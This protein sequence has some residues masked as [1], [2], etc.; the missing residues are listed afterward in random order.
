MLATKNRVAIGGVAALAAAAWLCGCTPAGPGSLLH[1]AKLIEQKKYPEAVVQL[2]KATS[3]MPTNAT[4]WNYLGLAYQYA[5]QPSEAEKAY[6]RALT[7]DRD[8]TEAHYNLGCLLLD[9][10]SYDG[11]KSHLTAY[12]MRRG[13]SAEA[14]TKL[15][16]AQLKSHELAA[17]EKSLSDALKIN[18][19]SAEALNL[20][21]VVRVERGR[22]AEAL[23]FFNSALSQQH[24]YAPTV[25]NLAVLAQ[26][27]SKDK[28]A[29]LKRYRE[30]VSLNPAQDKVEQIKATMAQLESEINP[31]SHIPP[32]VT[33]PAPAPATN[34]A[35]VPARAQAPPPVTLVATNVPTPP[36]PSKTNLVTEAAKPNPALVRTNPVAESPKPASLA[37]L[38]PPPA[39]VRTQT[40]ETV[41]V[42]SQPMYKPGQDV[43]LTVAKPSPAGDSDPRPV[44]D[45]SATTQSAAQK[46]TFLQ[47]INPLNLLHS[48]GK[49]TTK[50][51]TLP[52][53]DP[54]GGNGDLAVADPPPSVSEVVQPGSA[55]MARYAY[56]SPP[57]ATQGNRDAA[58]RLCAQGFQAQQSGR[59]GEAI[60]S[61]R[62]AV[63]QDP[64]DYRANYNLAVALAES[65]SLEAALYAY[66]KA[67]AASPESAEARLNF[68]LTLKQGRYYVDSATELEKVVAA[69]PS[70]TS[71][72]LALGNLYAQQLRQPARARQ[73]Y[74]KVLELE[75]GHREASS[76]H[77]WLVANPP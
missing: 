10:G 3:L 18:P 47:K 73:H 77:Y 70:E 30:Y 8:L 37:A 27:Y 38:S 71:A 43:S 5:G 69:S 45:S 41:E 46:R 19:R 60:K 39:P 4:A 20:A 66:E 2:R 22:P 62:A 34:A 17:A 25:L 6:S 29:A 72:H 36:P 42:A 56:K 40:I 28:P 21:G 55:G 44:T 53:A 54:S 26:V 11:A 16:T 49:T 7:L 59:L 24:N 67:L 68:A 14:L 75:P 15:G 52:Q 35:R 65:G 64:S 23:N 12:T 31:P 63:Q 76:I 61:Y 9:R 1:G 32:V 48:S 51:T 13:G 33:T 58:D 74:L 50:S 57:A